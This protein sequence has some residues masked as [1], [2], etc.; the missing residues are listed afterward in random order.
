MLLH[1][2]LRDLARVE[3][4]ARLAALELLLAGG[5]HD[6]LDPRQSAGVHPLV[7]PL[8][9]D[10]QGHILGLLRWPTAPEGM[11]PPVVRQAGPQLSLVARSVD[12][13]VHA[14]LAHRDARGE[15]LGGLLTAANDPGHLYAAG[16]LAA[17]RLP[18]NAYLLL[19]VGVT[20]DFFEE[21]I[22]AHLEKGD[23]KAALV[24]AD[25][26]C[27]EAPGWARPQAIR[28]RTYERVGRLEEA[29]DGAR[30]AL[31]EPIWTLG[32]DPQGVAVLAG[33]T[34]PV[35]GAPFRRLA[36]DASKPPA[37]RAA[38]LMDAVAADGGD[39]DAARAE[40]GALYREA[41]LDDIAAFV[42]R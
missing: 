13:W 36:E 32:E 20:F 5:S 42:D 37:D 38:H 12:A 19:K 30:V 11:H 25:R 24:T 6:L 4:P 40:L 28:A 8:A 29:R 41:G 3:P 27:R 34:E 14:E 39:W 31:L 7:V 26:A 35:T 2:T 23:E 1:D 18:L 21:L 22:E 16:Q 15:A 9:R 33:W 10:S 17:S